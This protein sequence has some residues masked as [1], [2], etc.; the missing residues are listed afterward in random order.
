MSE[1]EKSQS[2]KILKDEEED[3]KNRKKLM[4]VIIG[5]EIL[6]ALCYRIK[7]ARR[8]LGEFASYIISKF[9]LFVCLF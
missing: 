3:K 4:H 6:V 8:K 2:D 9:H 5:L 7:P 1:T